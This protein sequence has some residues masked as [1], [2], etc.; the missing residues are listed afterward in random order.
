[1]SNIWLGC[2]ECHRDLIANFSFAKLSIEDEGVF[3]GRTEAGGGSFSI[4]TFFLYP[5]LFRFRI[6]PKTLAVWGLI[7]GAMLL[8][9]CAS[10][11]FGW[12]EMGETMDLLLSRPIWIN[13]MALATWLI[14]KGFNLSYLLDGSS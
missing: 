7:G 4:G 11:L 8:V 10:I 9:S 5:M 3:I 12:I 1:M 14:F 13:E 2:D 6:V